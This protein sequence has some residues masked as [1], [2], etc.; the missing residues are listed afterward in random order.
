MEGSGE[1]L[2]TLSYIILGNN[3]TVGF[4]AQYSTAEPVP[5]THSADAPTLKH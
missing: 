4:R 1:E 5:S 3:S 2:I